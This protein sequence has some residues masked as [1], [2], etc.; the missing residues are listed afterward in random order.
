MLFLFIVDPDIA[1]K[2]SAK[3]ILYVLEEKIFFIKHIFLSQEL[4]Y[5]KHSD[6]VYGDKFLDLTSE[7]RSCFNI[8]FGCQSEISYPMTSGD[9]GFLV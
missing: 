5:T 2:L 1:Q 7:Y 8:Y 6:L 4:I 3:Y 9:M